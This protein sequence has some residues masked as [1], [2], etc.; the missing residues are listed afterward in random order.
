MCKQ[1]LSEAMYELEYSA[2]TTQAVADGTT[3]LV[4]DAM[5]LY[6]PDTRYHALRGLV[7]Q[8]AALAKRTAD[9]AEAVAD[10]LHDH[11]DAT[12]DW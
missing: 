2:S 5:E 1:T 10:V 12:R 6:A 8:I 9:A 4:E 7:A 11:R 3:Q